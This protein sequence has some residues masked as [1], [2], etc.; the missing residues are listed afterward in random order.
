MSSPITQVDPQD[1][2]GSCIRLVLLRRFDEMWSLRDYALDW[3]DPEGVHQMRVASRRLRSA[4]RDFMPYI[5]RRHISEALRQV[6]AV[7]DALGDVRDHDVAI[8]TLEALTARAPE[9]VATGIREIAN[10][11]KS[12]REDARAALIE[13]LE[14]GA[15]G[16]PEIFAAA[17]DSASANSSGK[18]KQSQTYRQATREII[19]ARLK[20][21]EDLSTSLYDPL[22]VGPLHR[23]RIAA[24]RLRY[25]L[26]LFE[27]VWGASMFMFAKRVAALQSSLGELHD[28]DVWIEDLGVTLANQEKTDPRLSVQQIDASFWLLSHYLKRRTRHLRSALSKWR[29]WEVSELSG[30]IRDSLELPSQSA[31]V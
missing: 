21:F 30:Q 16:L 11:R 18:R 24:K 7:A 14:K 9:S 10:V 29:E 5:R 15:A 26:E 20:E 13:T 25:A 28:C 12:A 27:Q 6:K 1:A 8:A 23:M 2:A 22:K 19:L 31:S 3:S 4:A 17:V